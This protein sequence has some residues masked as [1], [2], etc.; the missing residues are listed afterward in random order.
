MAPL[1]N[2][3]T[4]PST[5]VHSGRLA[6]IYQAYDFTD[7]RDVAVKLFKSGLCGDSVVRE[8]FYRESQRLMDLR[9]SSLI[10]MLD[11]GEDGPDGRPYLVLEWGG[12]PL[13]KWLNDGST[14][15]DWADFYDTVGRRILAGIAYA[16]SRD[17]SHRELKPSDFLISPL[18][19]EFRLA[20]FGVSKYP[21]FLDQALN[22]AEFIRP[23]EPFSPVNGYDHAYST[24]TDVWGYAVICLY[25]LTKSDQCLTRWDQIPDLL[26]R[27]EAPQEIRDILGDALRPEAA[28][29]PHNASVLLT[30]LDQAHAKLRR[31]PPAMTCGLILGPKA[32]ERF[33]GLF[34]GVDSQVK[35]ETELVNDLRDGPPLIGAFVITDAET[36]KPSVDP[37]TYAILGQ[38]LRLIAKIDNQSQA[39]FFITDV[40]RPPDALQERNRNDAWDCNLQFVFGTPASGKQAIESLRRGH[41]AFVEKD[42]ERKR[43]RE[44]ESLFENW[45]RLLQLRIEHAEDAKSY[46]YDGFEAD[47][48]RYVFRTTQRVDATILN[49]TWMVE[50]TKL[51]GEIDYTEEYSITLFVERKAPGGLPPKGRLIIDS[52]ASKGPLKRQLHALQAMRNPRNSRQEVLKKCLIHPADAEV[53]PGEIGEIEWVSKGLDPNKQ[54]VI[55]AA[56]ASAD[57]FKVEGPPGTGKTTFIAELILQFLKRNP[58]KRVLLTSQT[59]IAVDN[60]IEKVVQF[61]S[62]LRIT[63]VGFQE[64]KVAPSVHPHLLVNRLEP[65][66]QRT[67]RESERFVTQ[68]AK[69]AGFD[70]TKIQQGIDVGL[71]LQARLELQQ[72]E[73]REAEVETALQTVRAEF[74]AKDERGES[75][76]DADRAELLNSELDRLREELNEL[77]EARQKRAQAK[78]DAEKEFQRKYPADKD[79]IRESN[80]EL[81][82]WRD[83]LVGASPLAQRISGLFSLQAEWLQRFTR[84]D[85]CAEII[86]LDSD[87]IAGTCIGITS[88]DTEDEGYG[89]CIVDEASKATLPEALVPMI[90]S[91]RWVLVG[92]QRQLPP[93]VDVALRNPRFFADNRIDS[94]IVKETLLARLDRLELPAHSQ[95][96]LTQQHRMVPA[97]GN[98]VST[99]FYGGKLESVHNPD[100]E[101]PDSLGAVVSAPVAWFSTSREKYRREQSP[102]GSFFNPLESEW[103]A[104]LLGRLEFYHARSTQPKNATRKKLK[105]AVLTGYAAQRGHLTQ[106]I[107]DESCPNLEIECHTVDSY[108][109]RE[110]DVVIFSI[111]RSNIHGRAG[112]LS[113]LERIN[114]ALSRA[115]YA[116]WII[117]DADFCRDLGGATP[118]ADVLRYI[119]THSTDCLVKEGIS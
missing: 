106:R 18:D 75:T 47:E 26:A 74:F 56:L 105:V 49:E 94:E 20:D 82:V 14:F 54:A 53:S 32:K 115:R 48:N 29:R 70:S 69:R 98:L 100:R 50:G 51:V 117:G 62:D 16:H 38:S 72:I 109:G 28:E 93:F 44:E 11:F 42:G 92:D 19:G 6:D 31:P 37:T 97:I 102:N 87:L 3:Y 13:D 9:H 4:L 35:I 112:F 79:L 60:A 78:R 43:Q 80:D 116:L 12:T 83:G 39:K 76:A 1:K 57:V 17:T 96:M 73:K 46:D 27:L 81:S 10:R 107:A 91:E 67:R 88:G 5:P 66:R 63:R 86:L 111:T 33:R 25:V 30:R 90:R 108:Q 89:L 99:I 104:T 95:A 101:I 40:S 41:E 58:G 114:V 7:R 118:L 103:T 52:R 36:G 65:W 68:F 45:T 23:N 22:I 84:D 119:E 8:S 113:S 15:R 110:A 24:A 59:H 77:R 61:R 64:S 71:L 85:D 55:K 34:P 21:E 2:R